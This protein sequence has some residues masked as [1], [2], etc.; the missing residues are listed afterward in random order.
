MS[1]YNL[2]PERG[3]GMKRKKNT[4]GA[5]NIEKQ[6]KFDYVKA[7]LKK[8]G[9]KVILPVV[10]MAL[11][12]AALIYYLNRKSEE[13]PLLF[14]QQKVEQQNFN[15]PKM[16]Q[17]QVQVAE[18][19]Y[20]GAQRLKIELEGRPY[21]EYV[22]YL[23]RYC[24][25]IDDIASQL[26]TLGVRPGDEPR[27]FGEFLRI[28]KERYWFRHE[29]KLV[30]DRMFVFLDDHW[31]DC[32]IS[33]FAA[34]DEARKFDMDVRL[35]GVIGKFG[36]DEGHVFVE[37]T[38]YDFETTTGNCFPKEEKSSRFN[39]IEWVS[40]SL[41]EAQSITYSSFG[42]DCFQQG[43]FREAIRYYTKSLELVPSSTTQLY[44][45]GNSYLALNEFESAEADFS[46]SLK[47]FPRQHNSLNGLGKI[48]ERNGQH[49][50]AISY[51]KK[52]LEIY[53]DPLVRASLGL[54]Y[55]QLGDLKQARLSYQKMISTNPFLAEG[56]DGLGAVECKA[57]NYQLALQHLNHALQLKPNLASA[58][59]SRGAV[60]MYLGDYD[61]AIKDFERALSIDPSLTQARVN[62]ET[63]RNYLQQQKH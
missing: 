30:N 4:Y 21:E 33:S 15:A 40:S 46:K 20:A 59:N 41:S 1:V 36:P 35:V 52:S 6:G 27:F 37:A 28:F 14:E 61:S 26:S 43:R 32:D 44:N 62:I 54:A 25:M 5:R 51:Y 55:F 63:I 7:A 47:I 3:V 18:S 24:A 9:L 22:S 49:G 10:I 38:N 2:T 31:A 50:G 8:Y 48:R 60:Y 11:A 16:T 53:E 12:G 56:Y 45:R 19:L 39:R 13:K 29:N 23:S 17:A 34:F 58:Y 57:G 42:D